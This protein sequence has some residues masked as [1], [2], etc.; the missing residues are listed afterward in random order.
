[1]EDLVLVLDGEA[2]GDGEDLGEVLFCQ[3]WW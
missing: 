1:V 2:I 3:S